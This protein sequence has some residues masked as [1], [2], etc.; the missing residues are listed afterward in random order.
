MARPLKRGM[1]W[2]PCET[3]FN[4]EFQALEMIHGNDGFTW[5]IKRW[6]DAYKTDNGC[7]D[8]SGIH[9]VIAA[10][11][12]RLPFDKQTE[13]LKDCIDLGLLY[14]KEDGTYTSDGILNRHI[15]IN[16]KRENDRN[17]IKN[18]LSPRKPIDNCA[19]STQ[20]RV[21][22][23][24]NKSIKKESAVPAH[25][26]FS[27]ITRR[28]GTGYESVKKVK[29][30]DYRKDG[31]ILKQFLQD[32]PDID[33][34]RFFDNVEFCAKDSFHTHNLSIRYICS[35]FSLL[36]AKRLNSKESND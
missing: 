28:F 25:P 6:Q 11:T 18:E 5:L 2:F 20:S 21:E 23:N 15:K 13:I 27:E 31:K 36:E 9:G 3:T 30:M 7:I 16:K 19:I 1:D 34:E 12:A 22:K 35:N 33:I 24:K 17:L 32:F 26:L 8:L 29:Y 10:K 14:Q 4:K